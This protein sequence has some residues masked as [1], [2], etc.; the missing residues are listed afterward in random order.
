VEGYTPRGHFTRKPVG[1][2]VRLRS[3]AKIKIR[4]TIKRG[5]GYISRGHLTRHVVTTSVN[6][7]DFDHLTRNMSRHMP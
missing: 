7:G 5:K 2:S 4:I 3:E 1:T 6:T